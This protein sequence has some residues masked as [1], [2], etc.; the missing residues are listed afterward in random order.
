MGLNATVNAQSTMYPGNNHSIMLVFKIRNS[1]VLTL[2]ST[3]RTECT[4]KKS[5]NKVIQQADH[6]YVSQN[7][8]SSHHHIVVQFYHQNLESSEL[9]P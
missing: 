7:P 2:A 1:M 6:L 8:A 3:N 5:L 9:Q 4:P